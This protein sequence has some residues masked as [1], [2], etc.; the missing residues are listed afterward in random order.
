MPFV[1]TLSSVL[2]FRPN[3]AV[4]PRCEALRSNVDW[5]RVLARPPSEVLLD[6][7][8]KLFVLLRHPNKVPQPFLE[9]RRP[10]SGYINKPTKSLFQSCNA[11]SANLAIPCD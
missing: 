8:P 11:F 2:F 5:N 10:L 7:I 9:L 1:D 6:P 4:Q 3:A